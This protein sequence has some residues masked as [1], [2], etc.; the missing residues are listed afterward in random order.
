MFEHL[1]VYTYTSHKKINKCLN[2]HMVL[3]TIMLIVNSDN[4]NNQ[5]FYRISVIVKNFLL[6]ICPI[7]MK[8]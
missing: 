4:D 6:L 3:M 5:C 2:W 7:A 8:Q 1:Y